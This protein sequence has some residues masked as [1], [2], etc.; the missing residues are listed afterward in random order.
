MNRAP[1]SAAARASRAATSSVASGAAAEL[2]RD[3]LPRYPP[4]RLLD[5]IAAAK[6]T[7]LSLFKYDLVVA[8][9]LRRASV[10]PGLTH[11]VCAETLVALWRDHRRILSA[12]PQIA[13][14]VQWTHPGDEGGR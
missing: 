9:P 8:R 5:G 12:R 11:F 1:C 4:G 6:Q 7:S 13:K 3:W 2:V 10:S 14:E